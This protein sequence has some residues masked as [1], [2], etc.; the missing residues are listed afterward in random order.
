MESLARPARRLVQ[1]TPIEGIA[2]ANWCAAILSSGA[3]CFFAWAALVRYAG[4]N[5]TAYDLGFFDQVVW[6]ISQG[7]PG[8][9]SYLYWY[10]FFGQHLEPILYVYGALYTLW[11]DP[12]L[13]L[14]TQALATGAGAWLLYRCAAQVI[15]P[16]WAVVL[17]GAFL[18]ALPL[19]TALA[20]DFHPEVMSA[21]PVFAGLWFALRGRPWAAALV[22]TSLLLLK[23]DES[24][25]LPAL[26]LL[27]LLLTRRP[28][29][30][31]LLACLGIV[32]AVLAV[33]I[34]E[35]HWRH[36]FA[37]DLTQDYLAFGPSLTAAA[38][39]IVRQP[40]QSARLVLGDGG[41]GAAL[42]WIGG[43]GLAPILAPIGL[44]A[45]APELL[46]QLASRNPTQHLLHLHYGVEAVP[47]VYAFL[48]AE[49]RW[50]RPLPRLQNSVAA[51]AGVTALAAFLV[52]SP[53]RTG[54]PWPIP[55]D[56]HLRAIQQATRMIPPGAGLRA[57]STLAA[58]LSQR[59]QIFEFPGPDW[60][61]YVVVDAQAFHPG[62]AWSHG[63]RDAL[64]ALPAQGYTPI[65]DREGVQVWKR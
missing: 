16:W 62:Q 6:Q 50:L 27:L 19:H 40:L 52:A 41:L 45:A 61:S 18:L 51:A 1:V 39:T 42:A 12:R 43:T 54:S 26:A 60:G 25:V 36:G 59:P 2:A 14:I 5:S 11:A 46:L 10:D 38:A 29:P 8:L 13:L 21:L 28:L 37:G 24:L 9:T 22:W 55:S 48:L 32:W 49:L 3:A 23:E 33:G 30:S 15:R 63:Y 58:H 57:D 35:P 17:S 56:A 20:F 31:V 47:L 4:F 65:F 53:F 7:R 44:L 34:V 64:A